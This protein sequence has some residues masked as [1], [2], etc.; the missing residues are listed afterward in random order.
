VNERHGVSPGF[1]VESGNPNTSSLCGNNVVR[2]RLE[3]QKDRVYSQDDK[4]GNFLHVEETKYVP[5]KGVLSR[6]R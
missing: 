5:P 6:D 3:L 2:A 4:G 1:R